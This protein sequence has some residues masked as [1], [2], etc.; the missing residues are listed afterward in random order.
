VLAWPVAFG[1]TRVAAWP[2]VDRPARAVLTC[3]H[4]ALDAVVTAPPVA[5]VARLPTST[6]V[7]R[8]GEIGS[9]RTGVKWRSRRAP[10]R[11]RGLARA[12]AQHGGN[13]SGQVRR[14]SSGEGLPW[15]RVVGRQQGEVVAELARV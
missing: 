2:T 11:G 5:M 13:S 12:M 10:P 14:C 3:A 9:R 6:L 4:D 1:R 8:P 7:A 15:Q